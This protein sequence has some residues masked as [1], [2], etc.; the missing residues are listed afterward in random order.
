MLTTRSRCV[1]LR[2]HPPRI[3]PTG[4]FGLGATP[5]CVG[6][7]SRRTELNDSDRVCVVRGAFRA[8]KAQL[9]ATVGAILLLLDP[10]PSVG[11]DGTEFP[12]RALDYDATR[13]FCCQQ[14]MPPK[15]AS[16]PENSSRQSKKQ[17]ITAARSIAV[18]GRESGPSKSSKSND[19]NGQWVE[20]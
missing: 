14:K 20:Y 11:T 7:A 1:S 6:A 4:F 8:I 18:Q 5:T 10:R 15:R 2:T 3:P 19:T 13:H 12:A 17:K 9:R 16:P